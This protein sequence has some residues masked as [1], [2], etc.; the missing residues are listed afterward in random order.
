MRNLGNLKNDLTA[1]L[2]YRQLN[3]I[4]LTMP[5]Q[6]K[7]LKKEIETIKIKTYKNLRVKNTITEESN[8]MLQKQT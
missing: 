8:R 4:R 5:Q 3:E 1:L 2:E 6:N 7:K